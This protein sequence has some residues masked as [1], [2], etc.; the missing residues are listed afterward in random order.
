METS[1]NL[2]GRVALITGAAS[3]MGLAMARKFAAAGAK[4]VLGDWNGERLDAA[5]AELRQA[6]AAVEAAQGDIS[7]RAAAEAL[8]DR[9]FEAFGRLDILVNN[10]GVMDSMAGVAEVSDET[11]R[12]VFAINLEGPLHTMRRAIPKLAEQGGG[13]IINI[14]SVGGL[15]GG[16][17]G[18]AYTASKHA[19]IGLTKNTAY[20]YG[21]K[22]IRANA[23]APGGTKTNIGES[24]ARAGIDPAGMARVQAFTNLMPGLLEPE[25]IAAVALFLA[26]DAARGINGAVITVDLGWT[27]A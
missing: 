27:A 9:A 26:S 11:W 3:G 8:V 10:A 19:L 2:D 12:R 17:A 1:G 24:M 6:G 4:L 25:D 18:A 16:A 5:V 22:G 15:H 13:S 23:I 21:P 7:D 14:A 20:M